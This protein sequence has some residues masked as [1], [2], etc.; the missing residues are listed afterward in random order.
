MKSGFVL[1]S[2][3]ADLIGLAL[4]IAAA[5]NVELR[6][7]DEY[8]VIT[9]AEYLVADPKALIDQPNLKPDLLITQELSDSLWRFAA[10]YSPAQLVQLPEATSWFKSWLTNQQVLKAP[11]MSF[12][13]VTAAAGSSVLAT[14]VSYLAAKQS[15]VV[16]IDL[17]NQRSALNLYTG[18]D[19][20]SGVNWEQLVNLAGLPSAS[21]LFAGLPSAGRLRLLSFTKPAAALPISLVQSVVSMLQEQAKLIVVDLGPGNI[22]V[23]NAKEFL[24]SPCNL[25]GL[26]K[27]KQLLVSSNLV[28]RSLPKSGVSIADAKDYLDISN[29]F[30]LKSDPRFML[31]V[32]DGV[33]PGERKRSA[34]ADVSREI[35]AQLN[36]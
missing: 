25:L 20:K 11:I 10:N 8:P 18:I 1:L 36:D 33:I 5:V 29:L 30:H 2:R 15:E 6:L 23:N 27:L 16:L 19:P 24:I 3:D 35:L 9:G 13:S 14:A 22:F 32:A 4:Q 26:A 21:A 12:R 31:D 7:L 17:D 28:L 34:L